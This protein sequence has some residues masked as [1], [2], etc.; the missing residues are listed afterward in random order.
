MTKESHPNGPNLEE[1]LGESMIWYKELEELTSGFKRSWN[2][3]ARSGWIQKV[4]DGRKALY[5]LFPG[6]DSFTVNFTLRE[7]EREEFMH[8][9]DLAEFATGLREARKYSEGF[10]LS[11]RIEDEASFATFLRLMTR[12]IERRK[13]RL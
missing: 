9:P 4:H 11:F 6:E 12:L 5:Y 7:V 8:Q 10:A 3:S 13:L 1:T 2:H